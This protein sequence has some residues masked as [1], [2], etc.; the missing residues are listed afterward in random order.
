MYLNEIIVFVNLLYKKQILITPNTKYI[1]NLSSNYILF[2]CFH[3]FTFN[4]K[5]II[6]YFLNKQKLFSDEIFFK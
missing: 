1:V 2:S 4:N 3:L 5:K 6:L